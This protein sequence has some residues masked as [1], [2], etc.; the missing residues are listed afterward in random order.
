M[1]FDFE[2][3]LL[4]STLACG[5]IALFDLLFL[6]RRRAAA[7]MTREQMPIIIDYARSFFPILLAVF[8]LRSFLYEPFRIPSGSLKPSLL[9]GD[10]PLVNKYIYG[11]RVPVTHK[12]LIAIDAVKRGDIMVFRDPI[13]PHRDLIKRI[14]GIPGDHIN[15]INKVLYVNGQKSSQTF[16]KYSVDHNEDSP[17]SWQV[18]E[19][20]ENLLGVK[21][22]IYVI[23][24]APAVD[25]KD[26]VVPPNMY[27]AMGD[28]RDDS[29][30]S[31]MWGFVPDNN[32]IGKA[33]H[34][35]LS[36]DAAA[37]WG[38]QKI[39]WSRVGMKING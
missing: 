2:L 8:L 11:I 33:T 19:Y 32:I 35:L 30:D 17:Q 15:Y 5:V 39:R 34:V 23:P 25:V 10:F 36:W 31:R 26:I 7:G 24:Q 6:A 27:F 20:Q 37:P 16:V 1:N 3:I 21:H 12:K 22:D 9:V 4:Y 13:H 29:D 18:A 28:N 38:V 14:V